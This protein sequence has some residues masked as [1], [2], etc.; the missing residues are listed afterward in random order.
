MNFHRSTRR[1]NLNNMTTERT[2]K[3]S[4]FSKAHASC[5]N[6][7]S[8]IRA[9]R[10]ERVRSLQLC[11]YCLLPNHRAFACRTLVHCSMCN[12]KHHRL[13]HHVA[14]KERQQRQQCNFKFSPFGQSEEL[15]R[16]C[17]SLNF[18][19][20]WNSP[21]VCSVRHGSDT[22]LVS[23]DIVKEV[24]IVGS[25]MTIEVTLRGCYQL[26]HEHQMNKVYE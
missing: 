15:A 14:S 3:C 12:Q 5:E 16:I 23:E 10:I 9:N 6:I 8:M 19:A 21:F 13:L 26:V 2:E 18:W 11:L 4:E 20:K 7:L 24:G 17:C 25:Q 22:T 1:K